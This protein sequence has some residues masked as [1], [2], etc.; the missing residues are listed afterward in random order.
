MR[1][2]PDQ[3]GDAEYPREE[4]ID[5]G[6]PPQLTPEEEA[7]KKEEGTEDASLEDQS[8]DY[9]V[10]CDFWFFYLRSVG[11]DVKMNRLILPFNAG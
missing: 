6:K 8:G 2:L 4:W 1:G 11:I 5:Q 9:V 10:R 7:K 3:P